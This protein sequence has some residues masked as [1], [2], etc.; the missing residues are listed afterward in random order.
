[1]ID[2]FITKMAVAH[3]SMTA[4]MSNFREGQNDMLRLLKDASEVEEVK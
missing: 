4:Q 3:P 2:L 1:M